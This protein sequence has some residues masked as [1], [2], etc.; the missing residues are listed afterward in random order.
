[1]GDGGQ[2]GVAAGA[3]G[4]T[5]STL[6]TWAVIVGGLLVIAAV[7][8]ALTRRPDRSSES[9]SVVVWLRPRD[10]RIAHAFRTTELRAAG[11]AEVE[12]LAFCG[13]WPVSQLVSDEDAPRCAA[14]AR[15]A[16][17]VERHRT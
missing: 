17:R 12:A 13:R 10:H 16:Q 5:V 1:V 6:L 7:W 14:C 4:S 9:A 11:L 15:A 3:G 2:R 8:V